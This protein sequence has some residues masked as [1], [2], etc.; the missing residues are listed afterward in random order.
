VY[1]NQTIYAHPRTLGLGVKYPKVS[2]AVW[3]A[4]QAGLSGSQSVKSALTT[5]Q[6]QIKSIL[7][8]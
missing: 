5:A 8:G 6:S 3:T 2:E 4:I 1:A 7:A